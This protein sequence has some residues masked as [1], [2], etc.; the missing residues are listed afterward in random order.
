MSQRLP[1]HDRRVT[2]PWRLAGLGA[3]VA[4]AAVTLL[5]AA[6][7]AADP[8]AP[9]GAHDAAAAGLPAAPPAKA[10]GVAAGTARVVVTA[11]G[12]AQ[13]GGVPQPGC[14]CA[15]CV[16]AR[17]DPGRRR[18]VASLALRLPASGKTWL[19]DATPD[20][21]EQLE[22]VHRFRPHPAGASDRQPVDGVLLTHAHAGH[23]LGLAL[24]GFEVID[25]H[26]L[27]VYA[28]ARMAAFLRANGPWSLLVA[29]RNIV[30]HELTPGQALA[31]APGLTV[32]PLL[33]PHR[34][35]LSDTLGFVV[36]GPRRTLLYVPDTD[37]WT[38]WKPSLP[39]V[40]RRERVDVALLDGTFYSAGELPDRDVSRI[41]H[42]LMNVTMELLG[43]EVRGGRLQVFFT[44]LN[45]SN[46][47]LDPAGPERAALA[48]A[49]FQVLA[50]GQE[51]V[52]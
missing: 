9:A 24:F 1:H 41:G 17:R 12:T 29:R 47:A 11:L 39:E 10:P 38:A 40:L 42:P 35:E 26:D 4:A 15:R 50:E 18:H 33:V 21:G 32:T 27:P 44:H 19:I 2:V 28:S 7:P 43:A 51:L 25:S 20:L 36:R 30:L 23:Y 13:D 14:D 52:L 46:P 5:A 8:T 22:I 31:L 16:A 6:A 3:V 48:A 49:G 45:H 34:D 37:S